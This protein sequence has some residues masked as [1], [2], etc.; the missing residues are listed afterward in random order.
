M[1]LS[2]SRSVVLANA[3]VTSHPRIRCLKTPIQ[4][5]E[6]FDVWGIDFVGPFPMSKENRYILVAID[7]VSKWVEAQALPTND[8]RVV[9]EF[10]KKLFSRFGTPRARISD[11]GTHFCNTMLEKAL[12]CYGFTHG[13]ATAYH[14]QT[15]G[16]VE[17][18]NRG[19]KRTLEKTVGKS[20]KDWSDKL[21]D[22]LAP[23]ALKTVNLDVTEAAK[24]RYFQIHELEALRDAVYACSLSIKEKSKS[25]HDRKLKGLKE[26]K[27]GDR[28]LFYNS[29]L[30]LFGGKLKSKW[31]GPYIVEEV[32]PYGTIE[33]QNKVDGNTWK[34]NGHRLKHYIGGPL[35]EN[36]EEE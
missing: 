29:H 18:A 13:L 20:R 32:F 23:W 5:L 4:V 8:A 35:D 7:Y 3:P 15:S 17:N 30:K 6:V 33:L 10:L 12:Q 1:H 25:L 31:T 28:V 9:L 27:K 11:R 21:D 19:V 24:R 36:K 22:A 26:F 14:P 2:L 16:Q 34:V